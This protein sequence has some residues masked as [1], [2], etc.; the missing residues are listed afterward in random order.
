MVIS[1]ACQQIIQWQIVTSFSAD[2]ALL[3]AD[4][5]AGTVLGS[6]SESLA[7]LEPDAAL[8]ASA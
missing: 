4:C 5:S 1:N 8:R 2:W 7:E 6:S 3:E